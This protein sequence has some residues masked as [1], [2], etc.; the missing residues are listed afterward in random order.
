MVCAQQPAPQ[1]RKLV[2]RGM[3]DLPRALKLFGHAMPLHSEFEEMVVRSCH[4][5]LA[6][7]KNATPARCGDLLVYPERNGVLPALFEYRDTQTGKRYC[8]DT[9]K[10]AHIRGIALFLPLGTYRFRF[11]GDKMLFFP[12]REPMILQFPQDPGWYPYD[13]KT[14]IPVSQGGILDPGGIMT[15]RFLQRAEGAWLGCPS[16]DLNH[17]NND[18]KHVFVSDLPSTPRAVFAWDDAP[19][20][21]MAQPAGQK[22]R[23]R[24]VQVPP[25]APVSGGQTI[26]HEPEKPKITYHDFVREWNNQ[27]L[28]HSLDRNY[29][30]PGLVPDQK[31]FE[32]LLREGKI[33]VER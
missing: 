16:R 3:L 18:E 20:R 14:F 15:G 33:R 27:R 26:P 13:Q 7:N 12:G 28:L 23:R 32:T 8:I 19:I 5:V 25:S 11:D 30:D 22:Q 29:P 9:Q 4:P 6:A 31:T 17:G 10:Y 21:I 24:I 1:Q 2:L